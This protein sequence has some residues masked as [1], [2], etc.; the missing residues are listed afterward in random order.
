MVN[1]NFKAIHDGNF[2][3]YHLSEE[4]FKMLK[5]KRAIIIGAFIDEDP[6]VFYTD[7]PNTNLVDF[8][9]KS[10]EDYNDMLRAKK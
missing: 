9:L 4:K 6:V 2:K 7:D 8:I 5:A 1:P 10:S 3:K